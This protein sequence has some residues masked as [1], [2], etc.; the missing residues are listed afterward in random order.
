MPQSD[1]LEPTSGRIANPH[2]FFRSWDPFEDWVDKNITIN[3]NIFF[4]AVGLILV[5]PVMI[6]Y[7]FLLLPY[8]FYKQLPYFWQE[9]K[10]LYKRIRIHGLAAEIARHTERL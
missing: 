8:T 5:A 6:L 9:L 4:R 2:A 10:L 1:S 7:F 3:P